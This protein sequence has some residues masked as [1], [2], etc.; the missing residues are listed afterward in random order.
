MP[1]TVIIRECDFDTAVRQVLA[2]I[3][4]FALISGRTDLTG[5]SFE[6]LI[7][8]PTGMVR[9]KIFE[10]VNDNGCVSARSADCAGAEDI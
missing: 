5:N 8:L 1:R 6:E 2:E 7:T 4:I 9:D 3:R 10:E